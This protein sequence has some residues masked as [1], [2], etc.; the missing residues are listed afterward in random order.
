MYSRQMRWKQEF[1]S[2]GSDKGVFY[3]EYH[4]NQQHITDRTSGYRQQHLTLPKMQHNGQYDR[5]Q[6]WNTVASRKNL[7]ISKT[8]NNQ[9]AENSCGQSL[10]QILYV[11]GCGSFFREHKK[12]KKTSQ[13][14]A[15]D[16]QSDRDNLL[17]QCHVGSPAFSIGLRNKVSRHRITIMVGTRK[18]SAPN[19][20]RQA[21]EAASPI[22]AV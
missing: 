8:V 4:L 5:D 3:L 11:F 9:H 16:A 14:G 21:T 1:A 15:K 17:C 18:E 13:H 6:L 19:P 20:N 22:H 10:S 12:R 7:Y 2:A